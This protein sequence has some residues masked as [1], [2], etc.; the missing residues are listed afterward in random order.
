VRGSD[1]G[2]AL[3]ALAIARV[4]RRK[5]ADNGAETRDA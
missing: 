4:A 3:L 2:L 5:R 1:A